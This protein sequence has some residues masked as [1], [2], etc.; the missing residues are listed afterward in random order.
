MLLGGLFGRKSPAILPRR[1]T[2]IRSAMSKTLARLW[3]ITTTPR[4]RSRRRRIRSRTCPVCGDA[5]RRGRL[6]EQDDLRLAQQR[7]G[8]RHLLALAA[9]EGADLA[10]QAGNRHR[11]PREQL[12][13]AVLHARLVE[14]ASVAPGPERS[15][16]VRGRGWRPRRGCRRAPGP[17]RRSRSR[18]PS[19]PGAR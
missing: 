16:R 5:E 2:K 14:D 12:A 7:A 19:R 15:P 6:V 17:D 8:D 1:R 9:G 10:A 18:A 11:Q 13:G 4:S 3:L